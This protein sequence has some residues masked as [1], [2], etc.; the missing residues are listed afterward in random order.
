MPGGSA[1]KDD[2]VGQGKMTEHKVHGTSPVVILGSPLACCKVPLVSTHPLPDATQALARRDWS[3]L[4][5][6][7]SALGQLCSCPCFSCSVH[8]AL[9]I[10]PSAD[11]PAGSHSF[12][13][14]LS[15]P[16][17]LVRVIL[18]TRRH[19]SW[20]H[21]PGKTA[22]ALPLLPITAWSL[23]FSC[24]LVVVPLLLSWSCLVSLVFLSSSSSHAPPPSHFLFPFSLVCSSLSPLDPIHPIPCVPPILILIHNPWLMT[25]RPPQRTEADVFNSRLIIKF[26]IARIMPGP[27][28][29]QSLAPSVTPH[30]SRFL[31][32]VSCARRACCSR[33]S[34]ASSWSAPFFS[35]RQK[36]RNVVVPKKR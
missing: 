8:T 7:V 21:A 30:P 31:V 6:H 26:P 1:A 34:S 10:H 23:P 11:L 13:H 22:D 5:L 25:V 15:G 29:T 12:S 33:S 32:P 27:P 2:A 35:F 4:M 9:S 36:I 24:F 3:V 19:A 17:R 20:P 14:C 28:L 16:S 18:P